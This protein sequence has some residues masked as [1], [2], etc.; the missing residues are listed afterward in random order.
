MI[1]VICKGSVKQKQRIKKAYSLAPPLPGALRITFTGEEAASVHAVVTIE[2]MGCDVR[3]VLVDSGSSADI[4]C[5]AHS[6]K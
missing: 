1:N 6:R 4:L 5:Y 2:I 3:W